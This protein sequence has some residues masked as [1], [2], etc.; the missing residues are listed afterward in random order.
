M[1]EHDHSE[2]YEKSELTELL[3]DSA[4]HATATP[5]EFEPRL[6]TALSR[7]AADAQAVAALEAGSDT[8][9]AGTASAHI[10][11]PAAAKARRRWF[12]PAFAGAAVAALLAGGGVAAAASNDW[13][14]EGSIIPWADAPATE[15]KIELPSGA[16]CQ[17]VYGEVTSQD[18]ALT[19]ATRNWMAET[20][21]EAL[22]AERLDAAIHMLRT[23]NDVTLQL[24]DGTKV[25]ASYGTEYYQTPD[26][27]YSQAVGTV[28][29]ESWSEALAAQGF[30]T[31]LDRNLSYEGAWNCPGAIWERDAEVQR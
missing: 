16:S 28:L 18:P 19:E 21:I 6:D 26:M 3:N 24:E 7:M 2:P 31:T 8:A 4:P 1:T 14:N 17:V 9:S 22:L 23:D 30:D 29:S 25:D 10:T 15:F 11:S 5:P 12:R 13:W 20:D 27:E